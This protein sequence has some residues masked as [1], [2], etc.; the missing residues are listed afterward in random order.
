M[1][2]AKY[3]FYYD[4]HWRYGDNAKEERIS[5]SSHY[6]LLILKRQL[7]ICDKLASISMINNFSQSLQESAE[8]S[9]SNHPMVSTINIIS[10]S[11]I[12]IPLFDALSWRCE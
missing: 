4:V 11:L 10:N 2:N 6:T 3:I 9:I 7:Y 12:I 1:R 8:V 5:Y